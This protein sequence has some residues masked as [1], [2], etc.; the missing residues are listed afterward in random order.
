MTERSLYNERELLV[1]VSNGN[2]LAFREL[3]N[4]YHGK[5]YTYILK[6]TGSNETAEDIV[7]D[8]FLK[9]WLQ[10]ERLPEIQQLN[11]Y[12]FKMSHNAA[13]NGLRRLAKR[14]LV[15][16]ELA[17]SVNQESSNPDDKLVRKEVLQLIHNAVGKLTPQQKE[18]FKLS[19]EEGMKQEDIAKRLNI[20]IFTVKRHLTDALKH[21]RTE[22]AASYGSKA[23]VLFIIFSLSI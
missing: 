13:L 19:R 21:L 12:L 23:V 14:T 1:Q 15:M 3:F 18:V 11:A 7:H 2:E 6:I 9:L 4:N 8:V 22:I 17:K 5:L 16:T 10:K 20:S